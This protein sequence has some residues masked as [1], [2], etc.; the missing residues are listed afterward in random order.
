[1][2]C[3]YRR[4]N[5]GDY[6][7]KYGVKSAC[8]EIRCGGRMI[9]GGGRHRCRGTDQHH[10]PSMRT[11]SPTHALIAEPGNTNSR[12]GTVTAA[13]MLTWMHDIV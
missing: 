7:I 1:M 6:D 2:I 9:V 8:L 13:T 12:H 10:S 11:S 3:G 4:F 5:G